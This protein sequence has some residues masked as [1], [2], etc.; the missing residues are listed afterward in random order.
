MLW[1]TQKKV[2]KYIRL[3][4]HKTQVEHVDIEIYFTA[5]TGTFI[6]LDDEKNAKIIQHN[7]LTAQI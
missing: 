2:Q 1:A 5:L 6:I 4:H 3:Q 7:M